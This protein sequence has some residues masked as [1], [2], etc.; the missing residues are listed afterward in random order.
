VVVTDWGGHN[1]IVSAP[2]AVVSDRDDHRPSHRTSRRTRSQQHRRPRDGRVCRLDQRQVGR[3]PLALKSLLVDFVGDNIP[4]VS[5]EVEVSY[6]DRAIGEEQQTRARAKER[7]DDDVAT[8]SKEPG[9]TSSCRR[10]ETRTVQP[11]TGRRQSHTP[12]AHQWRCAFQR[13]TTLPSRRPIGRRRLRDSRGKQAVALCYVMLELPRRRR[14]HLTTSDRCRGIGN[15]VA[16]LNQV[17]TGLF[18]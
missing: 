7:V 10:P 15:D 5:V 12:T 17:P 8:D 14:G 11:P 1:H 3:N 13:S 6:L 9:R 16:E 2:A 18:V 4:V